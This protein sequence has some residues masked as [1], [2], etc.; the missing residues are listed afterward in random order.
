MTS[1]TGEPKGVELSHKSLIVS[2]TTYQHFSAPW[3]K[4]PRWI[5]NYSSTRVTAHGIFFNALKSRNRLYV[6]DYPKCN[7]THYLDAIGKNSI[8]IAW[9]TKEGLDAMAQQKH[10]PES[11]FSSLEMVFT[12]GQIIPRATRIAV[13]TFIGKPGE[14]FLNPSSP[15]HTTQATTHDTN[16]RG[17]SN[18]EAPS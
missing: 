9:T 18:P 11:D 14:L 5:H 17:H 16:R 2:S 8:H 15:M 3:Y 10:R 1:T 6:Y 7:V 4:Q 12:G 13:N